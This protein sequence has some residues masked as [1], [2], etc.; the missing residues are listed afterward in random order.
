[1]R[2]FQFS[3]RFLTAMVAITPPT[4]YVIYLACSNWPAISD[5]LARSQL[6][7]VLAVLVVGL[8]MV[9]S[10]CIVGMAGGL[11]M[12]TLMSVFAR[13]IYGKRPDNGP[14]RR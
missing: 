4:A 10:C 7:A 13:A 11:I 5:L 6:F 1:M 2:R 8:G 9:A 12:T 14:R 3:L